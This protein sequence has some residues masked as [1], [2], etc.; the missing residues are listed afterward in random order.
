MVDVTKAPYLA[1]PTGQMVL[2]ETV[3]PLSLYA[4]NVERVGQNPQSTFDG[5]QH[6][7]V[8]FF[9]VEAGTVNRAG[10]P[11]ANTPCRI[12]H[13]SDVRIY[14][15]CG[16]VRHLNDRPMIEV[17]ESNDVQISQ[18]QTFSPGDFPHLIETHGERKYEI[19][20]SKTCTLFMRERND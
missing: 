14:C 15:M 13:C 6:V 10:N 17:V 3:Q 19:P 5:C 4:L 8:F 2:K 18:L 12:A 16:V 1:D 11:D 9:K 20:S 7:R